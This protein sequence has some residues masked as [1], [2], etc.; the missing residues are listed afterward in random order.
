MKIQKDLFI[1]FFRSGML[2]FGGGPSSIP[3]I[4]KEVVDTYKWV[5]NDEFGDILALGNTLP[6]PIITKIAGYI[7]YRVGGFFGMITAVSASVVPTIIL[8]IVLLT[9]LSMYKDQPWVTGITKGVIPVV[10]VL[11]AILTWEF[12][13]NAKKSLGWFTSIGLLSA[14]FLC[15]SIIGIHP[16]IIIALLLLFAIIKP[17]KEAIKDKRNEAEQ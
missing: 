2:G 4:Q 14:S 3:L 10:T 1:A 15:I 9:S 8:M 6:G 5:N 17:N 12:F 11:M 7:G 13:K 16:A